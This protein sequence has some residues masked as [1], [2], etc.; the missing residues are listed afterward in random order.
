MAGFR[1]GRPQDRSGGWCWPGR[2]GLAKVAVVGVFGLDGQAL[3]VGQL[4]GQ[5][6]A[7]GGQVLDPLAGF[8]DLLARGEGEFVALVL[9][10]ARGF[11]GAQGRV[12][13]AGVPTAEF[14]VGGHGQVPLGAGG[15]VPVGPV[16]HNGIEHGLPFG[17]D[18]VQGLVAGGQFLLLAGFFVLV[19]ALGGSGFGGGAD[20]GQAGLAGAGADLAEFVADP[21]SAPRRSRGG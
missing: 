20:G 9:G 15:G 11:G 10:E 7:L 12:L 8:P 14:G 6:V 17:V 19:A 18:V 21:I 5:R 1:F 2:E 3:P 13:A 16:G 4:A